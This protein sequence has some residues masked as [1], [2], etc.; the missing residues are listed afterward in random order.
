MNSWK[1]IKGNKVFLEKS[2]IIRGTKTDENGSPV[3][4]YVYRRVKDGW[5]KVDHITEPAFRAGLNR[6]TVKLV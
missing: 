4:A 2:E 5:Q 6:G 3:T 1:T